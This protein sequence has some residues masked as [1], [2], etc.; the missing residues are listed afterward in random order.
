MSIGVWLHLTEHHEHEHVQEVMS[1][2]HPH[3]HDEHHRHAHIALDPL[4]EPHTH[5]HEHDPMQHAHPHVP[6]LHHLINGTG[7]RGSGPAGASTRLAL[8]FRSG[9][10]PIGNRYCK[11]G[12]LEILWQAREMMLC[13]QVTRRLSLTP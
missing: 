2:A 7:A 4:G 12:S 8:A 11:S 9:L 13:K 5:F 3:V 10:D 1:H 6:D